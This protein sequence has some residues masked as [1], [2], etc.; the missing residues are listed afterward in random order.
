MERSV[1]PADDVVTCFRDGVVTLRKNRRTEGFTES[2][3]EIGYQGIRVGDLVVHTMDAFAGAVGVSDS[4]G[5]G[6]P[7]YSVCTIQ[8]HANSHYY[9]AVI[10]E[11]ARSHWVAALATGIRERSTDF[12]YSTLAVQP[13]PLPP[14]D[15]QKTITRFLDHVNER[16]DRYIRSK[17]RFITLLE[18]QRQAIVHQAVTRGL[19]P[20]IPLKSTVVEWLSRIPEHWNIRQAKRM[21][22]IGS[23]TTPPTDSNGLYGGGVPWVTTSELRESVITSTQKTLT[24]KALQQLSALKIH[25]TG[26]VAVAMYGATIGRA[27]ILGVPATVN[28]ACCVFS[29]NKDIDSWY[30]FFYIQSIRQYLLSMGYGGGQPNLSQKV[31]KSIPVPIPPLEEQEQI[32]DHIS[33]ANTKIQAGIDNTRYQIELLREYRTRLTTDVVTGQLDVREATGKLLSE[34]L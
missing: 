19:D 31:L 14:L 13:L 23:G 11:M 34:P 30:F 2:L 5:K 33:R 29:G 21:F 27:G 6:T 10:R 25:P 18:E 4:N 16:I 17:E 9:A 15:E 26:S 20:D 3:Q 24:E 7:V 12:R 8:T 32:I 22:A 28:Q 1:R